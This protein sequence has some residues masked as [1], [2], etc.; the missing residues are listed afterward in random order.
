VELLP[1]KARPDYGEPVWSQDGRLAFTAGIA[2]T[3]RVLVWDGETFI[4]VLP[5]ADYSGYPQWS[6]DGRLAFG[7]FVNEQNDVFIW[8][9]S[10]ATNISQHEAHDER[11]V[12][13][14]D[15]R[16][17]FISYRDSLGQG[18]DLNREV[19]LWDDGSLSNLSQ[20]PEDDKPS[21]QWSADGQNLL[22]FAGGNTLMLWDGTEILS[23]EAQRS[24]V[25]SADGKL[26]FVSPSENHL[27]IYSDEV[28]EIG[29]IYPYREPALDWSMD[30][31]LAYTG[32]RTIANDMGEFEQT[33]IYLWENGES[34][35]IAEGYSPVWSDTHQLAYLRD[36]CMGCDSDNNN[37][38]L[39]WDGTTETVIQQAV[40]IHH[41]LLWEN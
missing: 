20:S 39:L 21:L 24:P 8:D 12:W 17:A 28:L 16:V 3:R 1:E 32:S 31:T 35:L 38:L 27:F 4:D 26:A 23:F 19:Y 11:P 9:G 7:A 37:S 22:W 10:S 40:A 36:E 13:G 5:E 18:D 33:E 2:G 14:A 34:R 15:G 25:L 6:E 41:S 29:E 30:G